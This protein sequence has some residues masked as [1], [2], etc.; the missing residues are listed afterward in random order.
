M[1]SRIDKDLRELREA[2][3]IS[4]EVSQRITD[5]YQAKKSGGP[6][7]LFAIFGVLG[8][9]LIGLGI[10]LILAHNWDNFSRFTKTIWA[11]APLVIGQLAVGF[12]LLKNKSRAWKEASATFLYVG[13]GA[14][15][16]LVS[17]IYNIP[18]DMPEFL[19]TWILLGALLVYLLRSYTAVLLHLIMATVYA[20]NLGYFNEINPWWYLAMIAWIIPFYL[21]MLR[22]QPEGNATSILN[23]A[24][25][26]SL[27]ITFGAFVSEATNIVFLMYVGLF[28]LLYNLGKLEVF[29]SGKLRRNGYAIIGSLGMIYVFMLVTFEFAWAEFNPSEHLTKDIVITVGIFGMA[30]LVLLYLASKKKL[31]PFNLFQYAFLIFGVI[32]VAQY[33]DF[34]LAVV[35]SNLLVFGLGIFAIRIGNLR[36]NFGVLNY[37]LLIITILVACRFFDTNIDFIVRGLLF[38]AIGVG[39]FLANYMMYRKQQKLKSKDHE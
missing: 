2:H 19:M 22:E 16:S 36:N 6:R 37:G 15:I 13:I 23:W 20:C 21:R 9:L 3:V 17:Q 18:G 29:N 31:L 33:W 12:S 26:L 1:N 5:Y 30:C 27:A 10:I 11:F 24:I 25:P 7:K 4:D 39:F 38:V 35:L 28:G 8:S 14:S 32:F 34:Q